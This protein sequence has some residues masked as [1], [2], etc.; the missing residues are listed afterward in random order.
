[1]N[2]V[3]L[4]MIFVTPILLGYLASVSYARQQH[5]QTA[6]SYAKI[7]DWL[8]VTELALAKNIP[9]AEAQRAVNKLESLGGLKRVLDQPG[10]Y[11][12]IHAKL[13]H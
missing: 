10:R 1:M 6:R 7:R 5:L 9:L 2:F 12:V 8:T 4:A 13:F 11:Q 3:F